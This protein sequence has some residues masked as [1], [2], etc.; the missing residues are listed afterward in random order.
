MANVSQA[1]VGIGGNLGDSEA[2]LRQAQMAIRAVPCVYH[3]RSS[4]IYQTTPVGPPQP[5]YLNAVCAFETSFSPTEL[6]ERLQEIERFLGKE[7]KP[8]DAPRKI[9]LDIL[10]Y[11]TRRVEL[12]ELMIPHPSWHERLFVLEPLSDLVDRIAVPDRNGQVELW[13]L[14]ELLEGFENKNNEAVMVIG[15]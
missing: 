5:D 15:E 4:R 7:P 6:L 11:G 2:I 12:S 10:F 14:R 9:D 3:F 8:K 13:D 1:Y